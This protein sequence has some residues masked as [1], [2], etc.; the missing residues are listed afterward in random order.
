[1]HYSMKVKLNQL[2]KCNKD[3]FKALVT[4]QSPMRTFNKQSYTASSG[5]HILIY[6]NILQLEIK[7]DCDIMN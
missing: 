2:Y 7:G 1:M 6:I 5:T 4:C 3:N